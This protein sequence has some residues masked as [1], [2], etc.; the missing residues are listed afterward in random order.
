M[1][2]PCCENKY[3]VLYSTT[4]V[5]QNIHGFS[6]V[7]LKS[8]S[9]PVKSF[10][11]RSSWSGAVMLWN[12]MMLLPINIR[13]QTLRSLNNVASYYVHTQ[14]TVKFFASHQVKAGRHIN[15]VRFSSTSIRLQQTPS[16]YKNPS[17]AG[18]DGGKT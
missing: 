1:G 16:S 15:I 6:T 5:R 8:M 17:N 4:R 3:R 12:H 9:I 14:K 11:G 18:M 13:L 2:I 7:N 10:V